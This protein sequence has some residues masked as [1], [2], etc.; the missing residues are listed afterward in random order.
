MNQT[1]RKSAQKRITKS[2][3]LR[4][5]TSRKTRPH[6]QES[7]KQEA[8]KGR[9]RSAFT[10]RDINRA[11]KALEKQGK[12]VGAVSFDGFSLLLT[13]HAAGPVS[14]NEWDDVL[15]GREGA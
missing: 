13:T 1:A 7:R 2:V 5:T 3:T 15:I 6:A 12:T 8:S 10:Q 9:S 14:T 11:V 4:R